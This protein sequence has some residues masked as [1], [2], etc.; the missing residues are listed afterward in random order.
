MEV[1]TDLALLSFSSS[2]RSSVFS[3]SYRIDPGWMASIRSRTG[4]LLLMEP[5]CTN[6]RTFQSSQQHFVM[7]R[8]S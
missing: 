5:S 1:C 4:R 8:S 2:V 6:R 3:R 7:L